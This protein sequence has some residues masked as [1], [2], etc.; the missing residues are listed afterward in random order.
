MFQASLVFAGNPSNLNFHFRRQCCCVYRN[1][2]GKG[3]W[4]SLPQDASDYS[5]LSSLTLLDLSSNQLTGAFQPIAPLTALHTLELMENSFTGPLPPLTGFS[6]LTVVNFQ[7]NQ[8]SG[9]HLCSAPALNSH[10]FLHAHIFCSIKRQ[11]M[12]PVYLQ[13]LTGTLYK[14]QM[15]AHWLGTLPPSFSWFTLALGQGSRV[16]S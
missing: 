12:L 15:R 14:R 13:T 2:R 8:F 6:K 5:S 1:L 16:S 3:L 11:G 7:D 4:G 9:G 10:H